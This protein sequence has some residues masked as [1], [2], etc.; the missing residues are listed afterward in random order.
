MLWFGGDSK[1]LN[2]GGKL[3]RA[4]TGNPVQKPKKKNKKAGNNE[5]SVGSSEKKKK[6]KKLNK[7]KDKNALVPREAV[8]NV[9][10][11]KG[12]GNRRKKRQDKGYL[13]KGKT[14]TSSSP[15]AEK[16]KKE[17]KVAPPR[18]GE[19]QEDHIKKPAKGVKPTMRHNSPEG[20]GTNPSLGAA[21]K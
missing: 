9:G 1:G 20:W 6:K 15:K 10:A 16:G 21:K 8:K 19:F 17:R 3:Q 2:N 14:A 18:G 7:R 4:G 13:K 11:N 12:K 5:E